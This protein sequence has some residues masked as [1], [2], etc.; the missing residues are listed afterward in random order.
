MSDRRRK[1]DWKAI[2]RFYEA[3][4]DV[5]E[6]RA[7]SR[8][9]VCYHARRLGLDARADLGRRYDW[10]AI[11]AFYETGYSLQ[12]TRE[13]FGFGRNAWSDAIGRGA[14]TPRPR[15]EPIELILA[16]GRARNRTHVK[17]RL[18]L[19]KLKGPRC[20]ACGLVD[21]RS[22]PD[23][24]LGRPEQGSPCRRVTRDTLTGR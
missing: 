4:H 10:D 2:R 3:G 24:Y 18:L 9:T 5:R 20:E 23:G 12:E 16:N 13:Q 19:A 14:I 11:R 22:Q 6:C 17:T 1:Y 15:A 7:R 21:W 8:P